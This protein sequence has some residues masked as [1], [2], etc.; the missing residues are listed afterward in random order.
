[1]LL[2]LKIRFCSNFKME[3]VYS[4]GDFYFARKPKYEKRAK[5]DSPEAAT[6]YYFTSSNG[7]KFGT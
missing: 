2:C 3:N 4:F 5:T 6:K 7:I 1:M